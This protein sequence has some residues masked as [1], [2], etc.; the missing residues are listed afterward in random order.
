MF[1]KVNMLSKEVKEDSRS[2]VGLSVLVHLR[3][4]F[5]VEQQELQ[6]EIKQKRLT[7]HKLKMD[8]ALEKKAD[9]L[10]KN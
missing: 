4:H 8:K 5:G 3:K 9:K 10:V 2:M 1:K 7:I 6:E